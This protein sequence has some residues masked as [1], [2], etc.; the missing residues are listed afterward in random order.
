MTQ[1]FLDAFL[2]CILRPLRL[3]SLPSVYAVALGLLGKSSRW[4]C[5]LFGS[6]LVRY[7][8]PAR[9]GFG[10]IRC[11]RLGEPAGRMA[12]LLDVIISLLVA[13]V[14]LAFYVGSYCVWF[15]DYC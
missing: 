14:H 10:Q 4:R 8:G 3:A 9:L 15:L 11:V 6:G 1:R 2:D 7:D 13:F 12:F 5:R